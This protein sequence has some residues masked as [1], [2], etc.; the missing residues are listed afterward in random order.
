MNGPVRNVLYGLLD[1]AAYPLGMLFAAPVVLR[2][3]GP[4]GYGVWAVVTAAVSM[5]SIIAAGF[6]DANIQHVAVQ[7]GAGEHERIVRSVRCMMGINSVLGLASAVVI[8]L[9]AQLAASHIVPH[10]GALQ[11]D[12]LRSLYLA[13]LLTFVRTLESVCISTQRAFERYGAAVRISIAGRLVALLTGVA[14]T[15]AL[16]TVA[17][18]ML[19]TLVVGCLA[20]R[21]QIL[22]L[23]KLLGTDS[24]RP[25]F[26]RESAAPLFRFGVFS[27]IQAVS[28]VIFS[29]LDRLLLGVTLGAAPVAGYAIAAQLAQPIYGFTAA[30]LHFLF[31]YLASR[32]ASQPGPRLR[33]AVLRAGLANALFAAASVLALLLIGPHVIP[34]LVGQQVAADAIANL[35]VVAFGTALLSLSVTAAYSLC[36]LGE[37]RVVTWLNLAGATSS[38]LLMLWLTP[39]FG[40]RGVALARLSFGAVLLLLYFPLVRL[41]SGRQRIATQPYSAANACEEA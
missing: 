4:G 17:A 8:A 7:R 20:T 25:V 35:P 38:L 12:C 28:G 36:A 23:R 39:R 26:D 41:L 11:Q 5:G 30:G 19:V 3:L 18:I 27:W 40:A 2:E 13:A 10:E 15:F 31:P 32:A 29:Q 21:L 9:F 22:R 24:L 14:L 37:V 6:G 16:H 1:Y 34:K 33:R